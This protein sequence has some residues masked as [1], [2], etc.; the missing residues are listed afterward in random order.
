MRKNHINH[1]HLRRLP[2][3]LFRVPR[4][5][6]RKRILQPK[7]QDVFDTSLFLVR[8]HRRR[9]FNPNPKDFPTEENPVPKYWYTGLNRGMILADRE[10][11]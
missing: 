7:S 6:N 3:I 11:I 8:R 10:G 2:H 5:R 4:Y 9:Q 1:T